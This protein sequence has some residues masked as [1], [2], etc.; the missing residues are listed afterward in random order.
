MLSFAIK[1]VRRAVEILQSPN[2]SGLNTGAITPARDA[3]ILLW[4]SF[5]TFKRMSNVCKNQ[6]AIVAIKI[7]VNA[8]CKKSFAFSHKSWHTFLAPGIR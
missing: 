4:E 2:P 5:T 1:P 8:L 3:S 6:M 7:T